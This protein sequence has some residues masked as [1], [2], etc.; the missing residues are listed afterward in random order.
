MANA[1]FAC[2][3]SIQVT[4]EDPGVQQTTSGFTNVG[5]EDFN[6]YSAYVGSG[7]QTLSTSFSGIVG[8]YDAIS[9]LS[10]TIT[11]VA[12]TAADQYGGAGGTGY[13]ATDYFSSTTQQVTIVLNQDVT[14]FGIWISA[15]NSG[16]TVSLYSDDTLLYSFDTATMSALVASNSGYY[17][18]PT[19]AFL[20][21]NTGEPYAFVN[22]YD[23]N[24]SFDKIVI[25][26]TGFESD[27]YTVGIYSSQTGTSAGES[28]PDIVSNNNGT[29]GYNSVSMLGSGNYNLRF[30]GGTLSVDQTGTYASNFSITSNDGYIDQSGTSATFSGQFTD[31][32]S[33]E[34]G[35][36]IIE[37]SG[38]G[39]TVSL[40]NS[41]NT[42]TGGTL[43]TSGATLAISSSGALGTGGLDL[44]G[45]DTTPATLSLLANMTI[46]V[47]ITVS[48]DPVFN[49]ASGT[50]TTV[51]SVI[52][53][54]ASPGDVVVT[55]GGTLNLTAVNTYT[56]PTTIDSGS[57]LALSGSGS[58]STSSAVINNGTF[59]LSGSS[60]T[61]VLGGTY[62]QS[63]TGDLVLSCSPDSFQTV[64]VA[65]TASVDGELSLT[66]SAGTYTVGK[67][68]LLTATGGVTGEFST[69]STNLSSLTSLGYLLGYDANDVYLY[70]T[71]NSTALLQDV[72]QNA[73]A[74]GVAMN[75]QSAALLSG[76]TYDCSLFDKNNMCVSAGGRYTRIGDGAANNTGAGFFVVGYRPLPALRFGAFIDQAFGRE[77]TGNVSES[78]L[79]PMFGV[80][81]NWSSSDDGTGLNVHAST[82]FS[83][84]RLSIGRT[85]SSL[86]EA[87]KGI[88]Q[89]NGQAYQLKMSYVEPLSKNLVLA[90]Y[91]GLRYTSLNINGY[92]DD[93]L[94]ST[95]FPVSYQDTNQ[96]MLSAL[97]GTGISGVLADN[98]RGSL[99]AGLIQNLSYRMNDYRGTS[100][101]PG[102]TS[103]SI[104][105]PSHKNTMATAGAS[106][107]Y[108]IENA[109]RI[110]LTAIWQQQPILNATATSV[111]ASYTLGF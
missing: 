96:N 1:D 58:I 75:S 111:M 72:R 47:P 83:S 90:P 64:S 4:L 13:Y 35:R 77:T 23:T 34:A 60:S 24:G 37:N 63:S 20:N 84:N 105:M 25:S 17:G 14:Y 45:S 82:A 76:L 57:T 10:A 71:P 11:N 78:R 33:G 65:G 74:L 50:T 52:S 56:G 62:T 54:G 68:P 101:V 49:V 95:A 38:T 15:M 91:A 93:Q 87:A 21:Q 43:V 85:A 80:F 59:D 46:A 69:F 22:F 36:L 7:F 48:G 97:V 55:G 12:V 66:A 41:N 94:S 28:A 26:G 42:Y 44:V 18:N 92:M 51:S 79:G 86:T 109:G 108:D 99:S 40:T 89:S 31:A 5:V 19:T 88:T 61:V 8:G 73:P 102:F 100:I 67:Y 81:G 106:L 16:N 29:A 6:S 104:A 30:D 110:G 103:F 2:A 39:G 53:D 3:D 27:N 107:S 32:S 70:I 98:L 9:G